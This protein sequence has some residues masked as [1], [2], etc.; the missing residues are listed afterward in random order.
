MR[1]K[2]LRRCRGIHGHPSNRVVLLQPRAPLASLLLLKPPPPATTTGTAASSLPRRATHGIRG[3]HGHPQRRRLRLALRQ[4]RHAGQ[5]AM[6]SLM[7][8][9]SRRPQRVTPGL[10][11][12]AIHGHLS[13]RVRRRRT[14]GRVRPQRPPWRL[15]TRGQRCHRR[16]RRRRHMQHHALRRGRR[17]GRRAMRIRTKTKSQRLQRVTLGLRNRRDRPR[18]A[19]ERGHPR[20]PLWTLRRRLATPG[21]HFRRRGRR[22]PHRLRHA[23]LLHPPADRGAMRSRMMTKSQQPQRVTRGL[24]SR[25]DQPR[26]GAER[27]RLWHPPWMLRPRL[28]TLGQRCRRGRP[29]RRP[30]PRFAPLQGRCVPTRT[31]TLEPALPRLGIP[32]CRRARARRRRRRPP[33][34][35]LRRQLDRGQRGSAPQPCLRHLPHLHPR[36]HRPRPRRRVAGVAARRRRWRAAAACR[37]SHRPCGGHLPRL[38]RCGRLPTTWMR[39][40]SAPAT[41]PPARRPAACA[42]RCRG[43]RASRCRPR[44]LSRPSR[45]M[46]RRR[47]R[48]TRLRRKSS[49]RRVRR[50][51]APSLHRAGVPR[52]ESRSSL[53][54]RGDPRR[55]SRWQRLLRGE[56]RSRP[57]CRRGRTW[58]WPRGLRPRAGAHTAR[59]WRGR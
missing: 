34:C 49:R 15:A 38:R 23:L 24:L 6:R 50:C 28:A 48:R 39:T 40:T 42:P 14:G 4:R 37:S 53:L 7:T 10:R 1:T 58:T 35:A 16:G 12:R 8:K 45:M 56:T 25:R 33:R 20:H 59:A 5:R 22:Q 31:P 32:T 21:R 29:R 47:R 46:R 41:P 3:I 52:R 57:T 26:R 43:I 13:Q 36:H 51:T 11:S 19:G 9:R 44:L 54:W 18:H 55:G 30:A 17:A 2:S 27:G